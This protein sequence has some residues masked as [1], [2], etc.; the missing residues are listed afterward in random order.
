MGG[1]TSASG[2]KT[3]VSEIN[4]TPFVDILLVLL[5]IFMVTAPAMTR[6]IGVQLPKEKA[7]AAKPSP[8]K[9]DFL[10]IGLNDK[11]EFLYKKKKYKAKVFFSKFKEITKNKTF[12][13]VFIQ[14]DRNTRYEMLIQA[15]VY[16]QNQGYSDIGLVFEEK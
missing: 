15:M 4:V 7:T 11:G 3:L 9:V 5:I 8:S 16:L 1:N 13:K 12:E 2:K 10:V 6:S 14:S